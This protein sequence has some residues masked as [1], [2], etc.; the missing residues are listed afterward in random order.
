MSG[1]VAENHVYVC[2]CRER[3][4]E[5]EIDGKVGFVVM[6][7]FPFPLRK[8]KRHTIVWCPFYVNHRKFKSLKTKVGPKERASI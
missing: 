7:F 6:C 4:G 1:I 8:L 5:R 2:M 3:E